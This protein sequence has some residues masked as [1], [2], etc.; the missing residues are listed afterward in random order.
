VGVQQVAAKGD[1][2]HALQCL[3][4][5]LDRVVISEISAWSKEKE[6]KITSW[7]RSS[8]A[9]REIDGWTD[10]SVDI[11][12]RHTVCEKDEPLVQLADAHNVRHAVVLR[13]ARA[14][15]RHI[16]PEATKGEQDDHA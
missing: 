14:L 13:S 15:V 1:A 6:T 12:K 3:T 10:E 4:A 11:K 9:E 16:R 5:D 2:R 8:T 7:N